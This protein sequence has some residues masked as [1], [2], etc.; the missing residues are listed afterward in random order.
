MSVIAGSI[1][2]KPNSEFHQFRIRSV[3]TG[4]FL[5]WTPRCLPP[6]SSRRL[7]AP[8]YVF[9][10]RPTTIILSFVIFAVVLVYFSIAAL[11][12]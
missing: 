2:T 7:P 4:A 3:R 6:G 8:A 12:E 9:C 1:Y 10:S 5:F 11:L